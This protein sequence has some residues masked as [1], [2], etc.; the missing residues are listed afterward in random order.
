MLSILSLCSS[1]LSALPT[2][3]TPCLSSSAPGTLSNGPTGWP[4]RLKE[5]G[6][7][8]PYRTKQP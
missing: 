4:L 7:N 3:G 5:E 8:S 1:A 6:K 2:K